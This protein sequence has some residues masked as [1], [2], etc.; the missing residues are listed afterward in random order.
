[1]IDGTRA[2]EV[3]GEMGLDLA[4]IKAGMSG[5][6]VKTTLAANVKLAQTLGLTGTP[7]FVIGKE[8]VQGAVG[9][10]SLKASVDNARRCIKELTC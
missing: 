10:E 9:F 3:A 7:S 1:M 5:E 8:V 6:E 4:K 2:L